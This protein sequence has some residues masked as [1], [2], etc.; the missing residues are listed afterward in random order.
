M[1]TFQEANQAKINLKMRLCNYYWYNS[2]DVLPVD[3]DY[4]ICV[5]VKKVNNKIRK[6]IP[7]FVQGTAVKI[8]VD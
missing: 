1:S 2:S 4:Y 3:D 8:I 6:A 5:C 7:S